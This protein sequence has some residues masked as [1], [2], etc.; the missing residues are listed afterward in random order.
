M[1]LGLILVSEATGGLNDIFHPQASPGDIRRFPV[2]ENFYMAAVNNNTTLVS[3]HL[4]VINPHD[5]VI[6]EQMGQSFI[7]GK[8]VNGDN[9]NIAKG[10][11]FAGGTKY[12]PAD[13]A[14]TVDANFY[15]HC[16]TSS[17]KC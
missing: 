10:D 14:K 11:I 9:L 4:P 17:L 13:P 6:L 8:V 3:L 2:I 12:G 7:V 15:S 16:S 1:C 5:G